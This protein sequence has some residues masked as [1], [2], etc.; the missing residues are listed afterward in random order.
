MSYPEPGE[1]APFYEGY[2]TA[3]K[4]L[5]LVR[6]LEEGHDR[7]LHWLDELPAERWDYR[8][9]EGKWTIRQVVE[10]LLDGEVIFMNRAVRIARGDTTPLPGF[11][12]DD[13]AEDSAQHPVPAASLLLRLHAWKVLAADFFARLNEQQ[14]QRVGH[15][16]GQEVSVRALGRIMAGH[17]MHHTQILHE[18][19]A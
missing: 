13:Y 16:N 9:A 2:V 14:L 1:Y 8:Y 5:P 12:Q 18:R 19:Y 7:L 4:E 15:A 6:A 17:L 10:H 3:T 11:E